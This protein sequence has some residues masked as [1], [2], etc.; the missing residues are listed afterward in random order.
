MLMNVYEYN[1]SVKGENKAGFDDIDEAKDYAIAQAEK[2]H[3]D[4]DVI[5]AFTG[6]VH[7]SLVC[8]RWVKYNAVNETLEEF[9]D[10]KV[11]WDS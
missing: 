7:L 8:Y 3:C 1:V 6:E 2:H 5:N 9:Y 10:I 4:V 11:E